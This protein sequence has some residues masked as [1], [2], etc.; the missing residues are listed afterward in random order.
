MKCHFFFLMLLPVLWIEFIFSCL[1]VSEFIAL[2]YF[3]KEVFQRWK[4]R[5]IPIES[6]KDITRISRDAIRNVNAQ[7]QLKLARGVKTNMILD[8]VKKSII[9]R[10]KEIILAYSAFVRLHLKF[11]LQI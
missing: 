4:S 2:K 10:D 3:I 9:S 5:Q 11:S 6:Y 7:L 8:C 1:T